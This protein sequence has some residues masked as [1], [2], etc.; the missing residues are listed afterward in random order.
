MPADGRTFDRPINS[1]RQTDTTFHTMAHIALTLPAPAKWACPFAAHGG[2]S[3]ET[4]SLLFAIER[5]ARKRS[6]TPKSG[7]RTRRAPLAGIPQHLVEKVFGTRNRNEVYL[8]TS[9]GLTRRSLVVR[10]PR[11]ARGKDEEPFRRRALDA[12]CALF[13]RRPELEE[14]LRRDPQSF[15]ALPRERAG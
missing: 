9:T 4:R 7:E 3:R 5:L 12:R 1:S 8:T 10:D 13:G 2:R 6:Q 15:S 14:Q 11:R